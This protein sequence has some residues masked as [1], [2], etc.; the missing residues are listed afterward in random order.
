MITPDGSRREFLAAVGATAVLP[1]MS[2][3]TTF[4]AES[5]TR[6]KA[7][8]VGLGARGNWIAGMVKDHGGYEITAVADYFSDRALERGQ[9][10]GVPAEQCYSGL[11]GYKKLIESGVEAVFLETPP[12][13]FPEHA[14]AAVDAGCHV[15]VA[16]P[17]ACDVPG[18]L[19]MKASGEKATQ[20][21]QV[22]LIDFQT[23]TEPLII[24]G[25]QKLHDGGIGAIGLINSYY[26]DEG[27]SDPPRSNTIEDRLHSLIWC[28]DVALG[29]GMLVNSGIHM[30]DLALWMNKDQLPVSAVGSAE[31]IKANPHG[32]SAYVYSITYEFDNGVIINHRGDH[33][34]NRTGY[35]T[36]CVALCQDGHLQSGY[37]GLT[38]LLGN[39]TGWRG[40]Q[41]DNLYAKG[42]QRNIDLFYQNI[43]N[44][45]SDN[46]TLLPSI[47]SN[48]ASILGR[49]A[50]RRKTKLTMQELIQENRS[51][52]VDLS[53]LKA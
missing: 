24:E 48:L 4:G 16:K 15:F 26:A 46:P 3:S 5:A 14:E 9:K 18:T 31:V 20:K 42:A 1:A 22:F 36:E 49:E 51:L 17:V 35:Q 27:F 7:G 6:V 39:S 40:G 12:C 47:N 37:G 10:L 2:A 30:I 45:V 52:E 13:F 8:V 28:N 19:S 53:G 11:S 34:D 33:L 38:R 43:I 32:D 23:R 44:G 25:V 50:G 21:G 29:G 41:V